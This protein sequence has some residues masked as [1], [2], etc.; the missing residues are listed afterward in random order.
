MPHSPVVP[1][2]KPKPLCSIFYCGTLSFHC[3][4]VGGSYVDS[5]SEC[6]NSNKIYVITE[7]N[8]DQY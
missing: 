6:D 4:L 3:A 8:F 2:S 7:F 5:V 1:F